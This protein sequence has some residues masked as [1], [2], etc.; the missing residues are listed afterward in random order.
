M[1]STGIMRATQKASRHD[2]VA[3]RAAIGVAML[4]LAGTTM[5]A[6]APAARPGARAPGAPW[7]LAGPGWSVA[8]YSAASLQ[9]TPGRT[10]FFL[11]SPKGRKYPFYITPAA[12]THPTLALLDWSGD[13]SRI[14][15]YRDVG[16]DNTPTVVE[17]ISLATGTVVSRFK[18][19]PGLQPGG[20][21]RP[22]GTSMLAT[23]FTR[24]GIYRYDL[25]GHLQKV[26][27]RRTQLGIP[28]ALDS[29]S[30]TFLLSDNVTRLLRISNAGA[31]TRR[32]RIPDSRLC[33]PVRW[34]TATTALASCLGN[35]PHATQRLWL[36]PAGSGAPRP[37]TPALR[38]H[39]LFLGYVNAWKLGRR[40]YLQADDAHDTLSIV[41]QFRDGTRHT[42]SVPG[43][44]GVSDAIITTYHGR[45]LLQSNIGPGGP[46]SL[47]WFNP[48]TRSIRFIFRAPPGTYGVAGTIAYGY[49]N[50]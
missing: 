8:E 7:R 45:L 30:G 36:A 32:T 34:W 37:L 43:P 28:T 1:L 20:Y 41:R 14:L 2:A 10:T 31:I 25:D 44:A 17:Q 6:A 22:S 47:F 4:A 12:A 24:P 50:G 15:V 3:R 42:I 46:S 29:P 9:G 13:R 26:L 35:S 33:G 18:L 40:L 48:A 38:P 23:G 39:G 49:W 11:V 5:A 27:A 19:P 21:T 16:G